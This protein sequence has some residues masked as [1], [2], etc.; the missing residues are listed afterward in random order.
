MASACLVYNVIPKINLIGYAGLERWG[1]NTVIP[2]PIDYLDT[3]YGLGVDFDLAGRAFLYLRLK[4]FYH[5]DSFVPAND[6][7][8]LRHG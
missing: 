3:A 5:N 7:H 4:I 6:L 8:D 2:K 1:A